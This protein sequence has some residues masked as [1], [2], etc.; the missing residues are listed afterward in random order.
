M[1]AK[2]QS[3]TVSRLEEHQNTHNRVPHRSKITVDTKSAQEME[4][5]HLSSY[6]NPTPDLGIGT[7]I[8]V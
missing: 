2:R 3:K 6:Q 1:A 8:T 4:S 5:T 7:I